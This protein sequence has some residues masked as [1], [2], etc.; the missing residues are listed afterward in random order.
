LGLC[1]K[2][3]LE[4]KDNYQVF[5][6]ADRGIDFLGYRFYHSHTLLRKSIALK[7]KRRVAQIKKHASPKKSGSVRSTLSSYKGWMKHANCF[8][9]EKRY[10]P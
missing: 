7:M 9:L 6:V 4:I 3:N 10:M 2:L 8:N 1:I 5:P